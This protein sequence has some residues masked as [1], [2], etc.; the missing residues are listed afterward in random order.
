MW[1][2][3]NVVFKDELSGANDL[4]VRGK[5]KRGD[6]WKETDTHWRCRGTG[7]FNW[8]WKIPIALPI[9]PNKDY[10]MDRFVIQ[11]W[12][13]D[14]IGSNDLI[15]ECEIDLNTHNM[16]KKAYSRKNK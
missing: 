3:R 13:R 5:C 11:L 4:Y 7:S 6:D 15:G 14:L 8:R 16:L 2:T 9:D 1:I 10:G 12:D